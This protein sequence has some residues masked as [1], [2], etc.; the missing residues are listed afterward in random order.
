MNTYLFGRGSVLLVCSSYWENDDVRHGKILKD[1]FFHSFKVKKMK[2]LM[3][4]CVAIM[5]YRLDS[6]I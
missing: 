4:L 2:K 3:S 6:M 1:P 5:T